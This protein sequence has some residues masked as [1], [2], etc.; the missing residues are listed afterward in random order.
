MAELGWLAYA[1]REWNVPVVEYDGWLNRHTSGTFT[2]KGIIVHHDAS[3]MGPSSGMPNMIANVGNG[4]TPPPLAQTWVAY[5]GTWW[6]L[7]GGRCNHA[8]TG[9]G[10]GVIARDQGNRDSL[11]VET[12]HTTGEAWPQRQ[13]DSLRRGLAAICDYTGWDVHRA[14]CGHKE[15]APGRKPDPDGLD[16]NHERNVVN[17]LLTAPAFKPEEADLTPYEQNVL[18]RVSWRVNAI[19]TMQEHVGPVK[20]APSGTGGADDVLDED[21][22][23]VQVINAMQQ[24]LTELVAA[25][26]A[27]TD[28]TH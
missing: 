23:I 27:L 14:M 6:V 20:L 2:P 26:A 25:V 16:M 5:D 13:L 19:E 4:T 9:D 17:D 10:W 3:G 1:L 11:G 28:N 15:Y 18:D 8:G 7:A 12:D 21:V 24:T 22:P